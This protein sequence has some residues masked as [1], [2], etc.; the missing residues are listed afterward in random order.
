MSGGDLLGSV[1]GALVVRDEGGH[2]AYEIIAVPAPK[3]DE[4]K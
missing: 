1:A 3:E 4:R 2:R